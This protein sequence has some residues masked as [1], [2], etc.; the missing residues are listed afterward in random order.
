[1]AFN[2][3]PVPRHG[4][5][6]GLPKPGSWR[7]A[8]NSDSIYYAGSNVGNSGVIGAQPLPWMQRDQSAE[9]KL[10]PLAAIILIPDQ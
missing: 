10:P 2:F 5:R 7:E 4:Y 6:I 1:M 8:F 9:I 3:T